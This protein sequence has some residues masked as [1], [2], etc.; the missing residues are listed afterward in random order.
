M[1]RICV[2]VNRT[3]RLYKIMQPNSKLRGEIKHAR[4]SRVPMLNK[5]V[6]RILVRRINQAARS[7][8]P[9]RKTSPGNKVP[10]QNNRRNAET[11][12]SATTILHNNAARGLPPRGNVLNQ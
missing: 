8:D 5:D 7:L 2:K 10:A 11:G 6:R 9:R 3:P 1:N 12:V 4:P